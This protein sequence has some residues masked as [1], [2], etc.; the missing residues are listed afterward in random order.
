MDKLAEHEEMTPAV[1]ARAARIARSLHP[2][3]GKRL[4][5]TVECLVDATLKA[6]GFEQLGRHHVQQL[7]SYYSRV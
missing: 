5:A 1:I 4:D 3:A 6:Q 7:P 2:R